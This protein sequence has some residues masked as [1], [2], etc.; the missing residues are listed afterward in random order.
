MEHMNWGIPVA[1]DLFLAALGAGALMLAVIADLVG[2]RRYRLISAVGAFIAPWPVIGGVLLL[3]VD[4]GRPWLFWEM[5]LKRGEGL[6]LEF[7]FLL[8]KINST[9]SIGTWVLTIFV[10]ASF[11]YIATTIL[12]YPFKWVGVLR[13]LVGIVTLPIAIMVTVYTGVLLSASPNPLWNS[14]WL[15]V[16]FVFSAVATA[17]ASVIFV[18][19]ALKICG[20]VGKDNADVP[21][22]EK[23][24]S[25]VIFV[26]LLAVIVFMLA[27]LSV[28]QMRAI[29]GAGFGALW[30]VGII[31]LGL[32]V[33]FLYGRKDGDKSPQTSLVMAVLVLLGGFFLRYVI[34]IAG[35]VA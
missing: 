7:P 21:K 26:Q 20:V 22:L 23:M 6:T 10:W 25:T 17:T 29:I 15:P 5:L 2:G 35:Q 28:P 9:M 8:F 19:A 24:N 27:S 18:I 4:L 30:W 34:L 33:P 11:A 12:A 16:T 13:K 32:I 31:F 14:M 3:V 1:V